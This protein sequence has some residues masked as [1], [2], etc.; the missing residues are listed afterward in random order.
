MC[1]CLFSLAPSY[2]STSEMSCIKMMEVVIAPLY[3]YLPTYL[4]TTYLPTYL[5]TPNLLT[6]YPKSPP[7]SP[8]N[9]PLYLNQHAYS[10]EQVLVRGL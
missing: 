5:P 3:A 9:L 4:Y 6:I 1:V 2:I 7:E 8:D 10:A